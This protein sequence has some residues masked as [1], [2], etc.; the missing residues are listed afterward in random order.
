[1]VS[2]LQI[3][4]IIYRQS[5]NRGSSSVHSLSYRSWWASLLSSTWSNLLTDG[6]SL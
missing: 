4:T 1:M 5:L 2:I 3:A 6:N